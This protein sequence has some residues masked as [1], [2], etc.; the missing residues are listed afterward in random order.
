MKTSVY[1]KN[2]SVISSI[3]LISGRLSNPY[4]LMP[5]MCIYRSIVHCI[6]C[7]TSVSYVVVESEIEGAIERAKER[8]RGDLKI[9]T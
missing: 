3:I 5:T 4:F 9:W 8:E 6:L 7:R 1:G 2:L